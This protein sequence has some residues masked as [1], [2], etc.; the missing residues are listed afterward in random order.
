MNRRTFAKIAL[1]STLPLMSFT[2]N[3]W[4]VQLVRHATLLVRTK[5]ITF[6]VDPMLSGKGAMDPVA[7][8]GNDIRIPMVDLPFDVEKMLNG[9]DAVFVT[10]T[11]RDHWDAEAQKVIGKT[12][13][14]F[15]QPSDLEKIRGQGFTNVIAIEDKTTFK[16]IT[17]YRTGGQHGTGEI[18]Q[19]M[20]IVSGFVFD[21]G[22]SRLYIAG[23]TIW[24]RDVEDAL[25]RFT[26]ATIVVN[27]GG[28]QFPAGAPITM[29][30]ADVMSVS[31]ATTGP[32]VAVHMDTVNHCNVTRSILKKF[33]AE[34]NL[35][36]V[37]IPDDGSTLTF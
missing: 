28:A 8:A 13:P 1:S 26:P 7:N 2:K 31:K 12:K 9:I 5:K 17:I 6:L 32:V 33:I 37:R 18:G 21:N 36:N 20:G 35:T 4:S 11:H 22:N 19:K 10:H 16:G 25:A 15:C 30:E 24:C 29:S 34:N 3:S 23:D 14:V 27:A